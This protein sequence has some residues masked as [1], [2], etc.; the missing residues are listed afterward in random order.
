MPAG[1][2]SPFTRRAFLHVAAGATLVL[3]RAPA[4]AA[5]EEKIS[6]LIAQ[7]RDLPDIASRIEHISRALLGVR[8]GANTLIGGPSAPE[9]F[10]ARGDRFDCVTFCETVLA[11]ARARDIPSFEAQLRAI[12]YRNGEVDWRARNHDWAAWCA[13]NVENG[14]CRP[15][16]LG[17]P[18]ALK[19][20]VGWPAA[21][22]RR[23]YDIA[24]A[25]RTGLTTHR[26]ELRRGDII[27]FISHRP[28]LDYFH[29]GFVMFGVNGE[30]VLRHAS[31]S[32]RRVVDEGMTQFLDT[33]RVHYLT[34]L[35][36]QQEEK[37]S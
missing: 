8:Y 18:V 17:P 26:A 15:V 35:R 21:L 2:D 36:P 9:V 27:G 34:V 22:G 19:K 3:A 13:R 11:A 16:A 24:A 7:A 20:V 30:P 37:K 10:V 5:A 29:T 28:A 12:R 33:N 1:F 23:S 32:R 4:V 14:I 25:T 31:Q 6:A